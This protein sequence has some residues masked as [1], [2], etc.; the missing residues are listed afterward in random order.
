M[1][2]ARPV[3]NIAVSGSG[4]GPALLP[5]G[6][7]ITATITRGAYYQRLATGLRADGNA[8]ADDAV[9]SATSPDGKTLLVLT[10]GFNVSFNYQTPP[11]APINFDILNPITG[12]SAGDANPYNYAG[13][14]NQA[15]FLFVFDISTKTPVRKQLL[16][17]P[18]TYSGLAWSP[19]GT[20]F[21]VSG[22]IDD[23]ILIYKASTVKETTTYVPDAPFLILNHNSNDT[24]PL[25]K[26]DGG[27][28]HGTKAGTAVPGLVTGAVA[29]GF[30]LSGDGKILVV[31]DFEDAAATVV[32]T[33][34]RKVV[35]EVRFTPPGSNTGHGEY[36]Y[37]V[38]V[39][40][41][42]TTGA[43]QKSYVT[44]QRDD[45]VDVITGTRFSGIIKVPSGPNKTAW[46]K[47]GRYLYVACGNDDSVAVIDTTVDQVT[48]IVSLSRPGDPYKGANPN[49][50]A[51]TNDPS[52]ILVT[53]GGENAV[54]EV[55]LTAGRV[56]GRIPTGWY[57]SSVTLSADGKNMFVVNQKSNTGPNPGNTYYSWNTP[58]GASTNP[59]VKNEYTWELEKGGLLSEPIP[60]DSEL[61]YLS[62]IVD[63]NNG[64]ENRAL[65]PTMAYLQ[66]HIK[67]VI[68]IVN[69]NRTY[70]Q[71]LGDL[72]NGANGD[73]KL[74]FFTKDITPNLHA[75]AADF[76]TLDN[77]Y[78]A[79]ETSGV[80]W[81]WCLQ[82]HT[83]DF[84]E[85]T[86]PVDYGNSNG[87][88]LTYDW[89][90]IVM[91]MNLGLPP[92]GGHT[93][94]NTRITGILDPTGSSTILPGYK[95]P[96]ATENADNLNPKAVGGYIWEAAARAGLTF[97]NY[98]LQDDLTYYGTGTAFDP[99]LVRN[100]YPSTPQSS[101]STPSIR[102]STDIYYRAF[103]QRYPDIFRIEE[104]KREFA[105]YVAKGNFPS[106]EVMTIP[107]DHT[108]SFGAAI[109]GLG[110][111]QL[112]LAD[113]DYAI[114]EL[115]EALSK[116]K[117]WASTA[118][119]MLED[120]PQDGQDHVEAHRSII[121]IISPYTKS[122]YIDHTTYT[123]DSAVRTVTDLLG[124]NHLGLQDANAPAMS[125]V[126]STQP[127]LQSYSA[128]I[129][130]SLCAKPVASD[131]VP[132]CTNPFV[133]RT[134]RVAQLHDSAWWAEKT[135]GMNFRQP[136]RLPAQAFNQLLEYGIT[137]RGKLPGKAAIAAVPPPDADDK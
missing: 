99:K 128:I 53:L 30:A 94:F 102:T 28:L 50:I 108:G 65:N 37:W 78:D 51:V 118:I 57:P 107:H 11:Y 61:A 25:P 20:K 29:A 2:V 130:G 36:P 114:G 84:I 69:E 66:K 85:K 106:L 43:Y 35:G 76:V 110:T 126:F 19:D 98:G 1:A 60:D 44:S 16:F 32:N 122:H 45:E 41:D 56:L 54:A 23:R 13:T 82:G 103:D 131:L 115:V 137:G 109:E 119:V 6:Q 136:D 125:T 134:R 68:Y 3:G 86:Q 63:A 5:T 64:L 27:I 77:F 83:N 12:L 117:Y 17:I 55:D 96:A 8:D 112:E 120:D 80:G 105:D 95:D 14:N 33:V 90:G 39:K 127:N 46:S 133:K 93:I 88:G 91:N 87:Y 21:Y 101:P 89:Q 47:D 72:G 70:D 49:S 111:P 34:T 38:A 74:T 40:S 62:Q 42:P 104:W 79:S 7:Y 121:H 100:P 124:V 52:R 75:L 4:G 22:G 92:T 15:E 135:V 73:P 132:A 26:Y 9:S 129:P 24:A 97:R 10:S 18:D 67:H 31:A 113:H 71:V 59:T 81:N 116:S 123:T 58:Y 48:K